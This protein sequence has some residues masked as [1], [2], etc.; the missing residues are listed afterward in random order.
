MKKSAAA[1]AF[2]TGFAAFA[3]PAGP[4]HASTPQCTI[5]AVIWDATGSVQIKVPASPSGSPYCW[6]ARGDFSAAVG[7][8][9]RAI[10]TCEGPKWRGIWVDDDY[11]TQTQA[12]VTDIQNSAVAGGDPISV[13]GVY[14]PQT[15]SVMSFVTVYGGCSTAP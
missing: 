11:G 7:S 9:Q 13:D 8:L 14:G 6:L 2:L 3:M 15:K 10:A 1:L 5:E 4:A 12:A